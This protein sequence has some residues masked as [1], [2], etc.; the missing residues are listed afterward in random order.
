MTNQ[1]VLKYWMIIL[2]LWSLNKPDIKKNNIQ[3]L[4]ALAFGVKN[5]EIQKSFVKYRKK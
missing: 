3:T 2:I 5:S 1:Q 4:P